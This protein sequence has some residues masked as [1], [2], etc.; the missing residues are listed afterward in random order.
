MANSKIKNPN[1]IKVK[2]KTIL[3][4]VVLI[5]TIIITRI[6]VS[7]WKDPNIFIGALELHHFYYGLIL[8]IIT[9]LG[10]LFGRLH[11]RLYVIFSAIAIGLILDE[12][13]FVMAKIRGPITYADT[14]LSAT[15]MIFV[16]LIIIGIILFDFIGRLK[17]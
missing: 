14:L 15:T 1:L 11:P 5:T 10:I 9:T 6:L 3:F 12:S 7:F 4:M 2:N 13:L 16:V 8:L 17:K